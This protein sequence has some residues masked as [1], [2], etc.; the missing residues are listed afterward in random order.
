MRNY[1]ISEINAHTNNKQIINLI[2]FYKFH[3]TDINE[4]ASDPCKNGGICHDTIN[5]YTCS[6]A[7]GYTD[8]QCTTGMINN[9]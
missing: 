8:P 9:S 6:C 4:C 7:A 5:G 3:L 1:Q 2:C